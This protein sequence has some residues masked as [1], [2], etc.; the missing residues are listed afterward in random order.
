MNRIDIDFAQSSVPRVLRR[1]Q[2]A[3]WLFLFAA[4]ALWTIIALTAVKLNHQKNVNANNLSKVMHDAQRRLDAQNARK[5][6]IS[7]V[8]I[9]EAQVSAVNKAIEQLNL[10]VARPVQCDRIGNPCDHRAARH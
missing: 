1:T 7:K 4:I 2:M 5:Q 3:S 8:T 9:P 10:P 6:A